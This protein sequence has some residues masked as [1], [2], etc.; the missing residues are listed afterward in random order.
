MQGPWGR[1]E[2]DM[3]CL[4]QG[5]QEGKGYTKFP[6]FSKSTEYFTGNWRKQ[7]D[8]SGMNFSLLSISGKTC[9]G[10]TVNLDLSQKTMGP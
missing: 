2:L 10:K 7:W 6:N 3:C 8:G 1:N 5:N 9:Q 4:Q